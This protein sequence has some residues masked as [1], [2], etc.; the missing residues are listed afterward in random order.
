MD[1]LQKSSPFAH[2]LVLSVLCVLGFIAL[3]VVV[4][5][6][7]LMPVTIEAVPQ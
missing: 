1:S 2:P 4:F 6:L 7:F 5:V 3:A